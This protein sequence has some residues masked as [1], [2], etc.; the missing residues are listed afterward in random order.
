MGTEQKQG[1]LIANRSIFFIVT[2]EYAMENPAQALYRSIDACPAA[3][4]VI[5]PTCTIQFANIG[6]LAFLDLPLQEVVGS[7]C[8]Q[9]VHGAREAIRDCPL[10]TMFENTK[11]TEQEVD[12]AGKQYKVTVEPIVTDSGYLLGGLHVMAEGNDS[13]ALTQQLER[14]LPWARKVLRPK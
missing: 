5:D 7:K 14:I 9:L 13:E 12:L 4:A 6:M 1:V 2:K 3:I 11:R 8:F 10:M